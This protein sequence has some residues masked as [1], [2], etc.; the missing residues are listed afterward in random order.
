MIKPE[1]IVELLEH[2]IREENSYEYRY[3][4]F[5]PALASLK[6]AVIVLGEIQAG[7][8]HEAE[9]ASD[10]LLEIKTRMT[11]RPKTP[12]VINPKT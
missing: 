3:P 4:R 12:Q 1:P 8:G 6:A 9:R 11:A 7:N 10:A 2:L 5:V